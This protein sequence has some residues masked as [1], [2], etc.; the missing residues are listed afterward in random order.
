VSEMPTVETA[1]PPLASKD[2]FRILIMDT[3][4]HVNLLKKV[5]KAAGHS[6]VP[7]HTIEEALAFLNNTNHVD[8]IICA[9]YLEDESMFDF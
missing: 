5:C 1:S 9:A 8:V 2:T 3:V 7:A 4:E 6:V